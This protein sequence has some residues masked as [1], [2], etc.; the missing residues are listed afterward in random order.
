V[1]RYEKRATLQAF[2][3]DSRLHDLESR[4]NDAVSLAAAAAHNSQY[5]RDFTGMI[6]ESATTAIS[7]PLKVMGE[8]V[9]AP[10]KMAVGVVNYIKEKISGKGKDPLERGRKVNGRYSTNPKVGDRLQ[11]GRSKKLPN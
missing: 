3:T 4:L 8:V 2:Q 1:R 6:I 10:F 11:S 5:K 9:N 7:L